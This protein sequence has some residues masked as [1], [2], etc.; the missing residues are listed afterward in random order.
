MSIPQVS[1]HEARTGDS[2]GLMC[3]YNLTCSGTDWRPPDGRVKAG[4]TILVHAGVYKYNRLGVLNDPLVNRTVPLDGT[5]YLTADGTEDRPIVIK[6]A[7]DGEVV[8]DG[9]R[10]FALFDARCRLHVLRRHH[11]QKR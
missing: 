11:L 8:F 7:G 6:G 1:G 2:E 3:A 10:N 9:A 4:D 5:Y